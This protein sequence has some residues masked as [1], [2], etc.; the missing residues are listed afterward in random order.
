M[1]KS[2][3]FF[4]VILC[5]VFSNEIIAQEQA[6]DIPLRISDEDKAAV[7]RIMKTV[8]AKR[9]NLRYSDGRVVYGT[10]II[11]ASRIQDIKGIR[12]PGDKGIIINWRDAS[13][14]RLNDG[15]IIYISST[16][17]ARTGQN[18]ILTVLGKTKTAELKKIL[19]KY[20]GAPDTL[21]ASTVKTVD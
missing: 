14:V 9:V 4:I 15:S 19:A 3:T 11:S 21:D 6:K 1:K 8:D 16:Q 13:A 5:N 7:T 18:S 10:A 2:F 12:D 20:L 17:A